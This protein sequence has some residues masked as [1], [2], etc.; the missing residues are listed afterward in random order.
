MKKIILTIFAIC[1]FAVS[2]FAGVHVFQPDPADLFDL[3]H[4]FYYNWGV[5]YD[6]GDANISNVILSIEHVN[7]WYPEDN[8]LFM[9]LMDSSPEGLFVGVD[10]NAA[11]DDYYAG[12]GVLIDAWHDDDGGE[13]GP[14][15]G[16][17]DDLSY[18]FAS[19]GFLD[20]FQAYAADGN[21]GFAFDPDC[22]FYNDGIKVTVITDAPE[23]GTML[24]F[25]LGLA[26]A[27]V[28]RKRRKN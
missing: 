9:H 20:E 25:G 27:A 16:D 18:D 28:I 7:N 15:F 21:F 14:V 1:T 2:S 19:L 23:P 12:Q 13:Y 4:G 26:G 6:F 22:H 17:Y 11:I 24:L 10:N 5:N 3:D 8:M